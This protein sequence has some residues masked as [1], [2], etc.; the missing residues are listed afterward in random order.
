M[1]AVLPLEGRS[2]PESKTAAFGTASFVFA[3]LTIT[4]PVLMMIFFGFKATQE[5]QNANNNGWG[6]LAAFLVVIAGLIFAG[7][8]SGLSS[9]AG[10]ITGVVA[11]IRGERH[12]WR[13]IVGLVVNAPVL[14]M[15][16]YTV[17]AAWLSG[18]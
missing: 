8:V 13:P 5:G 12:M 14:T 11:L 17:V 2:A 4:L 18:G 1:A 6:D 9:V 15:V 16:A 10:T 3:I 7:I